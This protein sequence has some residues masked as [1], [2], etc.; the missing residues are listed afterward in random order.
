MAQSWK[1]DDARPRALANP[2]TFYKPSDE[3]ISQLKPGDLAKLIF[4]LENPGSDEPE[5]ERMWVVITDREVDRFSGLLDNDPSY[6]RDL[7]YKAPVV[8]EAK[9]IIDTSLTDPVPDPTE[10]WWGRCFAS[11]VVVARQAKIGYFY[12]ESPDRDDD[13]GWRFS[14]WR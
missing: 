13:S 9:H 12:R 5:A 7:A 1:L 8:F 14:G 10:K 11:R 6:I 3:V 2:H 4:L